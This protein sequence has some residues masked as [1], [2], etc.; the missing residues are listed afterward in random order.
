MKLKFVVLG[1]ANAGKTSILRRYFHGTFDIDR[2]PTMGADFYS[3]KVEFEFVVNNDKAPLSSSSSAGGSSFRSYEGNGESGDAG[4]RG[5]GGDDEGDYENDDIEGDDESN[6]LR[7]EKK[8]ASFLHP[9]A[10]AAAAATAGLPP[11]LVSTSTRPVSIQIWDTPGRERYVNNDNNKARHIASFSDS[12][13]KNV[14]AAILVYD[15]SSSTSFTHVLKWHS[16][17][18]E[19]IRRMEAS[20]ERSKPLPIVIVGNKIDIFQERD[21][22]KE[23]RKREVVKQRDVLGVAGKKFRGQ[24]YRYEYS[25]SMPYTASFSASASASRGM[26]SLGISTTSTAGADNAATTTT[27]V[28]SVRNGNDTSHRNRFEISTYMGTSNQTNYLEAI[29][30]NEVYRG[31]YLDSLLSSE[32]NSHPDK[33]MVNVSIV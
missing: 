11:I 32:D 2:M 17:L 3:K 9:T 5:G 1:G 19:R 13:F 20:G 21:T 33:D 10:V 16:E 4:G 30:N 6:S 29:L 12:F 25:A 22:Q 28:P 15:V 14:D 7:D 26:N 23:L 8:D 18:M 24:D 27:I 31:S